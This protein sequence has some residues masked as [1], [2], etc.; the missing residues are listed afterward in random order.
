MKVGERERTM[1]LR[2][3][4]IVTLHFEDVELPASALLGA[5]GEGWALIRGGLT[6]GRLFVAAQ[7]I[8]IGQAA[9]DHALRYAGEREQ[10]GQ[11]L[12]GFGAI[13]EKLAGMALRVGSARALL[14]DAAR[15]AEGEGQDPSLHTPMAPEAQAAMAKVAAS[16]AVLWSADEAVQVFGGYGYMRDY[17]VEKL[18]RD[19]KGTEIYEGANE[20]L[21]EGIAR[22]LVRERG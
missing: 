1:G 16:E 7:A 11:P 19:A 4:E 13:Q 14:Y 6:E 20:L 2:P 21:R 5:P 3:S 15:G 17:P 22:V 18:M 8:G 10:F 9:L 12:H